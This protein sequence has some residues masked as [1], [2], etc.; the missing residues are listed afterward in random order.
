MAARWVDNG[1]LDESGGEGEGTSD[2]DGDGGGE[3]VGEAVGPES[4]PFTPRILSFLM[5][6]WA[7][8]TQHLQI[9]PQQ[10]SPIG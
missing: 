9:L 6:Y 8:V 1:G 4:G 7:A 3:G 2:G 10:F 5:K